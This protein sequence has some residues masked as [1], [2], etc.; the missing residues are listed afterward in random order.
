M[1]KY[2]LS[3][4][5]IRQP[6]TN[7][8]GKIMADKNKISEMLESLLNNE[9]DKAEELFHEYVVEKSREIYENLI[10]SEIDE[11]A[12]DEDE[13]DLEE[14][15]KKDDEDDEMEESFVDIDEESDEEGEEE[16]GEEEGDEEEGDAT[17][18]FMSDVEDG[19][20]GEEGDEEDPATK[21]D[22]M[23]LKSEIEQ[24]QAAF[25]SFMNDEANEPEHDDMGMGDEMGM[26][27]SLDAGV[28][29]IQDLSTVR[30]YTE[31]IGG[32]T[33]D[34]FAKGGDNG[35]NTKSVVAGK[36]DMGGTTANIAKSFSTDKGGTE[37]GLASP[38]AGD[39]TAGLGNIHNRKDSKAGKTAFTKKEPGHGAEKKG[40][41]EKADNKTSMINGA[42]GRAK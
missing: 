30:E 23:D 36:N 25:D 15:S 2:N 3:I 13:D 6:V 5:Y 12:K 7:L 42:P 10:D 21:G 39:L 37:G 4:K 19:E 40:A 20:E 9:Q 29:Q 27:D 41:A 31:K 8:G 28:D 16:G 24:L 17:D 22:V 34:K 32:A 38:K 33:Y 18:D 1:P 26:G 35:A 11:A 14:A